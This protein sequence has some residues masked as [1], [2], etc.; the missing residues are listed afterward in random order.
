MPHP[1][2]WG[3]GAVR[4]DATELVDRGVGHEHAI[5]FY[6]Y[7]AGQVYVVNKNDI[8]FEYDVMCNMR[9]IHDV[10]VVADYCFAVR[11]FRRADSNELSD[12]AIFSDFD[13][14]QKIF[15]IDILCGHSDRYVSVDS[16][17]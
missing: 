12:L 2:E 10:A 8:V 4:S 15:C 11:N 17:V 5:F 7:V 13:F 1:A 16:C 3:Q 14:A 9:K 6:V